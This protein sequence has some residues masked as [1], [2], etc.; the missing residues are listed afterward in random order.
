MTIPVNINP[1]NFNPWLWVDADT[2]AHDPPS[3]YI[4]ATANQL[5][6]GNWFRVN[7]FC[8]IL[9]VLWLQKEQPPETDYGF[10]DLS[11]EEQQSAAQTL[12]GFASMDAQIQYAVQQLSGQQITLSKLNTSLNGYRAGSQIWFGNDVHVQA[13][14]VQEGG[15]LL[16]YDSNTGETRTL[17]SGDFLKILGNLGINAIVVHTT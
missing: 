3:Y 6:V 9:S 5:P 15:S 13:A 2:L 8:S 1:T 7:Q 17:A 10:P 12:K 11:T 14:I 4:A 16:V